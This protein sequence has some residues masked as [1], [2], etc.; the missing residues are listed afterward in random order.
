[1]LPTCKEVSTAFARGEYAEASL[2]TKLRI[3]LHLVI[4]WHCRRFRKQL[5]LIEQA[6]RTVIFP[7]AGAA[8]DAALQQAVIKRLRGL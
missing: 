8:A 1:M 2:G 3:Q 5:T 6:L 7:A 4:C